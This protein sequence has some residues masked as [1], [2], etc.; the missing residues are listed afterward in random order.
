PTVGLIGAAAATG[1]AQLF[2]NLIIWWTVRDVARWLNFRA[3]F[4]TSLLIWGGA[5]AACIALKLG[6]PGPPLLHLVTGVIV[7]GL[8]G[9]LYARSPAIGQSDREILASVLHGRESRALGWLG[10]L[11]K[12]DS[13]RAQSS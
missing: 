7:C 1:S 10:L 5:A 11:P 9:L 2:K 4:L 3:V 13:A 6:V 12:P 8:A